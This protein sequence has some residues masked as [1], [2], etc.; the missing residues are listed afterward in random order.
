MTGDDRGRRLGGRARVQAPARL[1]DEDGCITNVTVRDISMSGARIETPFGTIFPKT[2]YLRMGREHGDRRAELV[3]KTR[4]EAGVRFL[5]DDIKIAE[6]PPPM[7]E[8]APARRVPMAD[9]R[10]LAMSAKR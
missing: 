8:A 6:A 5:P 3:W 4:I 9:L 10:K 2:F 1:V 7:V